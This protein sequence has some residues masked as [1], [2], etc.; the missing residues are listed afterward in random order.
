MLLDLSG[1]VGG[2]IRTPGQRSCLGL[3]VLEFRAETF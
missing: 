1:V 2:R 3:V